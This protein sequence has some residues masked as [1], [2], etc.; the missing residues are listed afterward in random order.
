[1]NTSRPFP[2]TGTLHRVADDVSGEPVIGR[3]AEIRIALARHE[4]ACLQALR[5]GG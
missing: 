4:P 3:E 2:F 5:S 1:M